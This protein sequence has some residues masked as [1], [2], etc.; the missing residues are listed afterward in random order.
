MEDRYYSLTF[1]VF[2]TKI[3]GKNARKI[4]NARL[5]NGKNCRVQQIL[6]LEILISFLLTKYLWPPF[7]KMSLTNTVLYNM[8]VNQLKN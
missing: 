3:N 8:H 2:K 4:F 5:S 7:L 6:H 1:P